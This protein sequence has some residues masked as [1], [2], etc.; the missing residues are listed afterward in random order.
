MLVLT[1]N[2]GE[3]ICIGNDI[4]VTVLKVVG[5]QVKIGIDAPQQVEVHRE[6]IFQRIQKQKSKD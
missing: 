2:V 5:T 3:S 4:K 6:E 1:R